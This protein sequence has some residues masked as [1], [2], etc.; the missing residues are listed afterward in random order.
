[1]I[2]FVEFVEQINIFYCYKYCQ[3]WIIRYGNLY[4][5]NKNERSNYTEGTWRRHQIIDYSSF[6]ELFHS[7]NCYKCDNV[8]MTGYVCKTNIVPSTAYRGFGGLI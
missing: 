8:K 4:G 6:Q 2:I 3:P 7:L 1:M 5:P